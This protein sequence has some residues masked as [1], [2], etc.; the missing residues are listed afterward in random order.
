VFAYRGKTEG[1]NLY[2]ECCNVLLLKLSSDVALD[3]GG[4]EMAVSTYYANR[5]S[6]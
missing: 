1:V 5:S 2:S 3:K 4:L 6:L